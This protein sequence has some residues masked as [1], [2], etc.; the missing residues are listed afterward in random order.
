MKKSLGTPGVLFLAATMAASLSAAP[1]EF[2]VYFGTYTNAK[3]GSKGIYRARLDVA[4]GKLS[5]AELAAECRDPSF[6][7]VHPSGKF[8]YAIDESSDPEK[9]PGR[10]LAAYAIGA[11][12]GALTLLNEQSNGGPGPCHLAVDREGKC[13]IVANYSGG[14]VAAVALLPNGRLGEPGTVVQHTGS[15][16][17]SARQKEP[18]AH[19]V[20][21]S[22]DQRLVLAADLGIDLIMA[23]RLDA[24]R[25]GL[26]PNAAAY[27]KMP[28]GS[29]PRHLA[30][31]PS[32]NFLY[33]IN[34]LLC[35][36]SVFTF[37]AARGILSDQQNIST[38]PPGEMLQRG[39]STAELAVHPS[40]KFLF[41]SNRGHN[42]IVVY[43]IDAGSG[44]L[45]H[46]ENQSTQG[47]TPR[48]FGV[49]PTGKWL[50]AENQDSGTVVVFA[51]DQ[52]TGRLK[53]TGQ[54]LDV[55]AP[56]SA[57]FVGLE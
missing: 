56:V 36:M 8:L 34:E 11:K 4:T 55:P 1:K 46:V 14:S 28:P 33:V 5:A 9:S 45:T 44:R 19:A 26:R 16:V 3:T 50:L 29:G 35:T 22:P 18:H 2:L 47:R 38:L 43:A 39:Y 54:S 49:D 7:A 27:A 20:A 30:F 48:H 6:L 57:V 24:T 51:I 42:S 53:P 17:N 13:V 41:G 37:D 10:G 32:G 23:Y 12:G 25:A 21:L 52:K 15:S 31:H 40:G